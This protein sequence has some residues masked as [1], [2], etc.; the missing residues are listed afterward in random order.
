MAKLVEKFMAKVSKSKI[1]GSNNE[2]TFDVAYST[3]FLAIDFING[4][5]VHVDDGKGMQFSYV[6]AGITDG[7]CNTI[8]GRSGSGKSTLMTQ[9]VGNMAKNMIKKGYDTITG[10]TTYQVAEPIITK[11]SGDPDRSRKTK[12]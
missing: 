3:G 12:A 1:T 8:I 4:T 11:A 5:T 9:I 2:A 6:S 7:S 10:N